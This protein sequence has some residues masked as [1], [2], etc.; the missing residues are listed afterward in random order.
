[1][2]NDDCCSKNRAAR[3]SSSSSDSRHRLPSRSV[4]IAEGREQS[5][6]SNWRTLFQPSFSDAIGFDDAR[7]FVS[8]LACEAAWDEAKKRR[9]IQ[10]AEKLVQKSAL[11][12][13]LL[14]RPDD[15]R[16]DVETGRVRRAN[17]SNISLVINVEPV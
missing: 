8:V 2:H 14:K 7:R 3:A 12:R 16:V 15:Q 1:M 10:Q 6:V 5:A 13:N 17:A 4:K 9:L 11:E